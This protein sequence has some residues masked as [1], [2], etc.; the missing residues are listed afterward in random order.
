M[1][2]GRGGSSQRDRTRD[3]HASRSSTGERSDS[4][5]GL[6][7]REERWLL[8]EIEKRRRPAADSDAAHASGH[9][10]EDPPPAR[11]A[12]AG[13]GTPVTASRPGTHSEP[14]AR[15]RQRPAAGEKR[16][17]EREPVRNSFW[18]FG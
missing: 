5:R 12:G 8:E 17:P 11:P 4:G 7:E 9:D 3:V 6:T 2:G 10:G 16:R 13:A 15:E 18:K 1:E 14:A